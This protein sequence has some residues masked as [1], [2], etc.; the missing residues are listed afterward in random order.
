MKKT[1][2]ITSWSYSR[3]RDYV[4]CPFKAK[5]KYVD[6]I[7]EPSNEAMD[8]GNTIHK[9]AEDHIKQGG[10]LPA[11]LKKFAAEFKALRVQYKKR[12]H[13]M[14]VEETWAFTRDWSKTKWDDWVNCWVRIKLDCGHLVSR[15]VMVTTDWKTGKMD[16]RRT[17]EYMEQ[18]ELYALGAL[19]A[20]EQLDE[21]HVR[22][23]FTDVGVMYPVEGPVVY[24]RNAEKTLKKTWEK[25]V[26]PML[27]DTKFAPRPNDKC[28]WCH[29][30]KS[31]KAAGGG[32][33]KF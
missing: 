15:G 1:K 11:E 17:A 16:E 18:L 28:R 29:Y 12:Q 7:K 30:R 10:K 19:V 20:N 23:G 32:Q 2:R 13:T 9:M 5:L 25:K 14:A 33:C 27:A 6:R 4:Q 8:R 24:K 26:K 3:Y 21:V 31:N 22:L